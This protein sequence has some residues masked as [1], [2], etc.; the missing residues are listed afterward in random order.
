[1]KDRNTRTAIERGRVANQSSSKRLT[2]GVVI[3][4][5]FRSGG[6]NSRSLRFASYDPETVSIFEVGLKTEFLDKR[7]RLNLAAYTSTYK[8]VQLDFFA[9]F[10]QVVNGVLLTSIR[11]TSETTNAPGNGDVKGFEADLTLA[12][13]EGLTLSAS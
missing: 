6:A 8:D 12:P 9:I 3:C 7:A 11:T 10:R 1:L 4:E 13:A 5:S 2:S